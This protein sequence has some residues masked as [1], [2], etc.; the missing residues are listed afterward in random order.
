METDLALKNRFIRLKNCLTTLIVQL[1]KLTL[2][3][4]ELAELQT[5]FRDANVADLDA[6]LGATNVHWDA[7]KKN[8]KAQE[9]CKI[10]LNLMHAI[11]SASR[12]T[13]QIIGD[14]NDGL[15]IEQSWEVRANFDPIRLLFVS[16]RQN[17]IWGRLFCKIRS[18]NV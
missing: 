8:N 5:W 1:R 9:S 7:F 2:P 14:L 12:D 15:Y 11:C 16:N 10:F 4:Y 13:C 3:G 17:L 6:Y 18:T